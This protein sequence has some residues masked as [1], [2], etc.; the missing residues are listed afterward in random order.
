MES[1]ERAR[2]IEY[3][4]KQE[5]RGHGLSKWLLTHPSPGVPTSDVMQRQRAKNGMDAEIALRHMALEALSASELRH[6]YQ[7]ER[8]RELD[9]ELDGAHREVKQ[10]KQENE[11]LRAMESTHAAEEPLATRERRTL[12]CI[13]GGLA[14]GYDFDLSRPY[15]AGG[16]ITKMM[17]DIAL[18]E[19]TIGD[20]LKQ[21]PEAMDSRRT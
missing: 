9:A 4:L 7:G 17:P 19:R 10:L 3:L 1:D 5:F 6:R 11:R 12:L 18:T 20:Y 16:R 15:K 21:V 2:L 13:I 8:I 14:K